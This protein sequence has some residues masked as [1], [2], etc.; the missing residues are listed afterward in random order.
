MSTRPYLL[1][2]TTWATV[3]D[4]EYDVAVLPWGSTEAH[5]FHLPYATDTMQCDHIAGE[6][7]RRAWDKG[8][9]VLVLP[10]VP[11]GVNTG[12]RDIP[13]TINMH[14][15]TQA[16]VLHDVA[17]SLATQGV[18]K[19]VVLNGHGGNAF[20]PLVREVQATFDDLFLCVVNWYDVGDQDAI[21]DEPGDHAGEMETSVM[22]QAAPDGVRPID[23]A[24]EGTARV[25]SIEELRESWAWAERRWTDVT[26]DTGVGNPKAASAEKGAA[27][28][29]I[30]TRK[31]ASL[32]VNLAGADL[33]DLYQE[34]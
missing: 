25:F 33:D 14:P 18:S 27:Y 1:A 31:I 9:Q 11:F 30:V 26:D 13:G 24:G 29:D 7:A 8:A 5:N 15:S 12:H 21:F 20:K 17:E 6:A 3:R 28:V 32:L 19:L 2:E 4:T 16:S 34:A 10:T 22:L 23:E